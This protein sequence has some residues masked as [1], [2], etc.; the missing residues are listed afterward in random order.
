VIYIQAELKRMQLRQILL[1]GAIATGSTVFQALLG[2]QSAVNEQNFQK[3]RQYVSTSGNQ[4]H[5]SYQMV[6]GSSEWTQTNVAKLS[7]EYFDILERTLYSQNTANAA[8]GLPALVDDGTTPN[9]TAIFNAMLQWDDRLRTVNRRG[10][11]VTLL[12]FPQVG[13]LG[14]PA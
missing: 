13:Q 4:Q 14:G 2:F 3:G 1:V 12:G 7:E 6:S 8:A 10:L 5:A 11:D 9:T